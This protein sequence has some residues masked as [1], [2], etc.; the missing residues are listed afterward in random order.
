M[1]EN[2][3]TIGGETIAVPVIMNFAMLERAWPAIK[4]S[5]IATDPIEGAA[6]DIGI[7]SAVLIPVRPEL[8]VIEIKKRL[9]VNRM[10]DTDERAGLA[11][12]VRRLL[13]QS[14]LVREGEAE[15]PETPAAQVVTETTS[16]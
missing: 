8:T 12:A 5:A 1:T 2:S 7:I 3:V 4:A 13:I 10:A 14:G 11:D 16:T 6:A 9:L 15:P